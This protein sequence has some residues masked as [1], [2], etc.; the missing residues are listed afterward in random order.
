MW[1]LL[2]FVIGI[3]VGSF[4]NVVIYRSTKEDLKL[5]D[6]P[7]SFC[8]SCKRK[9]EWYDNIPVVSYIL[10]KGKCRYCGWKIPIRYPVVEFSTGV[11]FLINRALIK[12]PLLFVSSCVIVSALIAIS[13]IDFE[14]FLIPDYLNFTVLIFSFV[15][16][17][18]T[19]FLEHLIS[20]LIVTTIFLVL[21]VMYRDGLGTGDV[22]L[23]MGIGF[24]LSPVPSIFAI[25]IASISGILYALIKGKGKMDIKTR[26]PFGPFL[27]LGG[28]ILF[29][30][31]YG[32]GWL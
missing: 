13:L 28:Y 21:K 20:F 8:P 4:L 16:A 6:P 22:I 31:S 25:L 17:L 1:N 3:T 27:A 26:I 10:L 15:V 11:L 5:W 2:T 32:M 29:L 23:A 7:H 14:T 12:D 24:L 30:I 9:I 19:S 18:R